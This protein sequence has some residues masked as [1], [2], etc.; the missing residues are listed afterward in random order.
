MIF[1][2]LKKQKFF[3]SDELKATM[4]KIGALGKPEIWYVQLDEIQK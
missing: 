1:I 4:K 2:A 3:S